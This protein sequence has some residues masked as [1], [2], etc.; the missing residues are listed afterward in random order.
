MHCVN[1]STDVYS[2]C[3]CV[4]GCMCMCVKMY[5]CKY[6]YEDVCDEECVHVRIRV[7]MCTYVHEHVCVSALPVSKINSTIV[8]CCLHLSPF[9]SPFLSP[10]LYRFR[11]INR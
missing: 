10:S 5:V 9:P 6:A 8:Y 11:I 3:A 7:T 1:Q 2:E 4:G